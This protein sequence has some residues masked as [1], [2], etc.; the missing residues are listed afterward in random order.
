MKRGILVF[1]NIVIVSLYFFPFELIAFPG[2]NTKM[3]LAAIALLI[4]FFCLKLRFES[5][6]AQLLL[7][8]CPE[9]RF[10]PDRTLLLLLFCPKSRFFQ[11]GYLDGLY[12]EW[13]QDRRDRTV[14]EPLEP[15]P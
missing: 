8:F 6:R 12:N 7:L 15:L 10:E 5:G 13:E 1:F 14:R 11:M 2:I 3:T 4:L 9:L